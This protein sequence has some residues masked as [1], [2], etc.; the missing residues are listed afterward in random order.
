M[1]FRVVEG[2]YVGQNFG[3]IV[4]ISETQIDVR[5]IVPNGLGGWTERDATLMLAE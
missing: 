4:H 5:E 2:N 1:V 3:R